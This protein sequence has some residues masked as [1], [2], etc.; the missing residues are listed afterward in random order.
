MINFQISIA[1]LKGV[2]PATAQILGKELGIFT[3]A[4]LANFFPSRYIDRTKFYKIKELQSNSFEVQLVGKIISM[5]SVKQKKREQACCQFYGCF[6]QHGTR[7]VQRS[8][9][10]Q[11]KHETQCT[12]CDFWKGELL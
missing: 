5:R 11:G 8:Q 6:R 2:G 3:Y 9:M 4:D 12:L 1:F 7:L 10:D